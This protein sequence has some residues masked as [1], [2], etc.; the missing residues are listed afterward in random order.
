MY[1][2]SIITVCLNSVKTIRDAIES[3]LQQTY[4]N[5]EYIIVD[6]ESVDGTLDIIK[7]YECIFGNRMKLIS[8]RDHGIY[9]AMNKGIE[10]ASGDIIGILNSDDW[11]EKDVYKR[12]V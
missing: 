2:I 11:Y 9:D 4:Q 5:F 3:L 10:I 1:K 12:Q 8:E 7:E 6:G